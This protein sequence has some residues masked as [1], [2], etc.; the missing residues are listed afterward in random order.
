M[1]WIISRE[2]SLWSVLIVSLAFNLGFAGTVA[3]RSCGDFC[4]ESEN[5]ESKS[6]SGLHAELNLTS[7][8]QSQMKNAKEELL[9][10]IDELNRLM[11][12]EQEQLGILL[13]ATESDHVAIAS[14]LDEISSL[15]RQAQQIVVDHLLRE[16]KLL[17]PDQQTIFAGIIRRRVCSDCGHGSG[18]TRTHS[19]KHEDNNG[20]SGHH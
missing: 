7:H 15:Q 5:R 4:R 1:R 16:K 18:H 14:Q 2:N 12:K 6:L 8:Q 17:E 10:Q 20:D 11:A 3:L 19:G 9:S 13:V